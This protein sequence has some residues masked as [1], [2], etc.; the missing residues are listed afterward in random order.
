M[1]SRH[2]WQLREPLTGKADPIPFLHATSA[3]DAQFSP[4]GRWV[5]YTSWGSGQSQIYVV[6]FEP[7]KLLEKDVAP[8]AGKWQISI[9]EGRTPRWRRDGKELFYID[10]QEAIMAVE[11]SGKGR[12]FEVGRSRRLFTAP[13]HPFGATYDVTPDGQRF[14]W[15]TFPEG[16]AS[17]LVLMVNWTARIQGK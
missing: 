4:D 6:P 1:G 11:V 3:Y 14:I 12:G 16:D 15:S 2:E 9:E 8:F 17:S 7:T 13:P 5:A 10:A